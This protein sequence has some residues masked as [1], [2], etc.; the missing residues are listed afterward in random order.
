MRVSRGRRAVGTRDGI[1]LT[2]FGW[3]EG[4]QA[5]YATLKIPGSSSSSLGVLRVHSNELTANATKVHGITRI[6]ETV[7]RGVASAHFKLLRLSLAFDAVTGGGMCSTFGCRSPQSRGA[8]SPHLRCA[9]HNTSASRRRKTQSNALEPAVVALECGLPSD[10]LHADV[11]LGSAGKEEV[12]WAP[13]IGGCRQGGRRTLARAGLEQR[14]AVDERRRR[15]A[16]GAALG[17]G[18]NRE[19]GARSAVAVDRD[20]GRARLGRA[21]RVRVRGGCVLDGRLGRR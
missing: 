3:K 21:E 1:T 14:E 17:R 15:D 16:D 10:P 18:R 2:I 9:L 7:V 5:D 20:R 8:N 11:T 13:A 12:E 4:A 19:R 6:T